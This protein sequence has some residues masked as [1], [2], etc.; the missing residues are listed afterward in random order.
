VA[1]TVVRLRRD[2]FW[3][4]EQVVGDQI[5]HQVGS[6]LPRCLVLRMVPWLRRSTTFEIC[7]MLPETL[8]NRIF[9]GSLRAGFSNQ[10]IDIIWL[11]VIA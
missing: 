2:Q 6:D 3:D 11:P 7:S 1:S 9:G 4:P 5:E 10:V 8:P